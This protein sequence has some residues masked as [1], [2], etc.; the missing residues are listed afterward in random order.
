MRMQQC[1]LSAAF[2][3]GDWNH[4]RICAMHD[5]YYPN[6]PSSRNEMHCVKANIAVV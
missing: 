4:V 3:I 1:T 6:E 5:N 2:A